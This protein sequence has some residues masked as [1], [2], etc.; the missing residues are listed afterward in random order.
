MDFACFAFCFVVLTH[1]RL[2]DGCGFDL[3]FF[4]CLIVC[5]CLRFAFVEDCCL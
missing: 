3:L 5:V 2:G 4:C 1:L